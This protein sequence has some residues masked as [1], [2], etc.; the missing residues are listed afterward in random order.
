MDF[1]KEFW[2]Y[3]LVHILI[4]TFLYKKLLKLFDGTINKRYTALFAREW[5]IRLSTILLLG[6]YVYMMLNGY[7]PLYLRE[8][9][10]ETIRTASSSIHS[11]CSYIDTI[12]RLKVEL[13]STFWWITSNASAL[14]KSEALK[15]LI[16]VSFISIN[17]I[18]LLGLNRFIVQIVYGVDKI[19]N[20]KR[21]SHEK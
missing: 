18:A 6:V 21:M 16:W 17:S 20:S 15:T 5:T 3:L 19:F 8:S 1:T 2:M 13:D 7:E 14:M 4:V 10:H 9:L 12:L 11:Q